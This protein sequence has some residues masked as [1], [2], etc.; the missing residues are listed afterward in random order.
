MVL[1]NQVEWALHSMSILASLPT[2]V[3]ASAATL[4]ELYELPKAYLQKSL[5]ALSAAGLVETVPGQKGGYRLARP[6]EAITFLDVVEAVEGKQVSFRCAEIRRQGPCAAPVRPGDRL[7]DI[8]A[9]MYEADE[10]W[11]ASLR[12]H[13]LASLQAQ[14][15]EKLTPEVRQRTEAWLA[16]RLNV[17]RGQRRTSPS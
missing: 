15:A 13:T 3:L 17:P 4:A 6:A 11:R 9:I 1:G 7:C 16:P 14:L 10:A 5:Q 8:A 12:R 2:G